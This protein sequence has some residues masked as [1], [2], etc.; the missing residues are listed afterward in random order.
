MIN[1][2]QNGI[3][4][5]LTFVLSALVGSVV[6]PVFGI[7]EETNQT[8]KDTAQAINKTAEEAGENASE[9]G[10][11]LLNKTGEAAKGLAKGTG[12]VL[13]DIGEGMKDLGK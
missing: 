9:V 3:F 11:G 5:S 7:S 1:R 6:I 8:V 10:S 2:H 13:S 12:E 4:L